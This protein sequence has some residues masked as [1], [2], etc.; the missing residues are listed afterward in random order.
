MN[1]D[2]AVNFVF[3][4][5]RGALIERHSEVVVTDND[6]LNGVTSQSGTNTFGDIECEVF[7]VL[8]GDRAAGTAVFTTVT[9]VE[10]DGEEALAFV[11]W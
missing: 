6:H 5:N 11:L 3:G 4:G 10:H 7:F 9:G 8:A 2:K 1:A